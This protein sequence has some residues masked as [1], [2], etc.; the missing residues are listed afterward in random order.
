MNFPKF[1][2]LRYSIINQSSSLHWI[3]YV[4]EKARQNTMNHFLIS[5]TMTQYVFC[6][7]WFTHKGR[8]REKNWMTHIPLFFFRGKSMS[9]HTAYLNSGLHLH[10]KY[11]IRKWRMA[12]FVGCHQWFFFQLPRKTTQ[13]QYTGEV[14][15]NQQALTPMWW[16]LRHLDVSEFL[17]HCYVA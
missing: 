2:S 3:F 15:V 9:L 17:R 12:H 16:R 8:Q 1:S 6:V 14:T 5:L 4:F 13:S 11:L 10:S 7:T